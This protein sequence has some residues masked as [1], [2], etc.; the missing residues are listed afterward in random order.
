MERLEQALARYAHLP[1]EEIKAQI[2]AE[3]RAWMSEQLD[4]I[5]IVVLR[6]QEGAA[7][8]IK[9]IEAAE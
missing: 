4:D 9:A 7:H 6:R 2:L 3:V 5:S 1:V 8:D